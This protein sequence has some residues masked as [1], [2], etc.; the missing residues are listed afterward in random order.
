MP[1]LLGTVLLIVGCLA[2]SLVY[3]HQMPIA[4]LPIHNHQTKISPGG[5][6][7][8]Q[9]RTIDLEEVGIESDVDG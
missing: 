1:S 9:L 3:T 7:H 6:K 4:P 5:Q 2:A 8:P